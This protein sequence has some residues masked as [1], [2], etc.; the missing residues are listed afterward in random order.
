MFLSH[1][2]CVFR[3][4]EVRSGDHHLHASYI[5][6]S[7]EYIVQIILVSLLAMVD[8][9][10]YWISEI[11]AHLRFWSAIIFNRLAHFT[12]TSANLNRL[13]GTTI[14]C[15]LIAGTGDVDLACPEDWEEAG[16]MVQTEFEEFR[17]CRGNLVIKPM[18]R[19]LNMRH[20]NTKNEDDNGRCARTV[21]VT[22]GRGLRLMTR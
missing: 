3:F 13:V 14:V 21:I 5:D 9:P 20:E 1:L 11:D 10:K 4:I 16:A 7:L 22:R 19:I 12:H 17:L 8:S 6:C 15:P 18:E 2:D